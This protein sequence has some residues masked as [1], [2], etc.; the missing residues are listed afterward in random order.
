[1]SIFMHY[2]A[3]NI[4]YIYTLIYIFGLIIL[5]VLGGFLFWIHRK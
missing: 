5:I 4:K 3:I 2:I 1:M